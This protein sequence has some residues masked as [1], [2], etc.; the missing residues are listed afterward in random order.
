MQGC[1]HFKT[2]LGKAYPYD[3]IVSHSNYLI[4]L[5]INA[6]AIDYQNNVV[7]YLLRYFLFQKYRVCVLGS[8]LCFIPVITIFHFNK[9]GDKVF[10]G[11][12]LS[13]STI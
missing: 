9:K 12:Y 6:F 1:N 13:L 3:F 5:R 4:Q 7:L 8:T 2:H 11:I 10:N